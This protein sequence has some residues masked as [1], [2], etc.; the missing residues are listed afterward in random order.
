MEKYV[1]LLKDHNLK[2]TAQRLKLLTIIDSYGHV[3][4]EVLYAEIKKIY[5]SVSLATLYKNINNM[6]ECGL[7]KELKLEGIK[8][9][10]EISK[11]EHIHTVCN[12]CGDVKDV[13]IDTSKFFTEVENHSN[14]NVDRASIN[15]FGLCNTC[16]AS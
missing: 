8:N 16:K 11:E 12:S 5:P 14:I 13:F 15:I 6:L 7:L 10:Y 1:K 3:D 4:I 9:K 2:S